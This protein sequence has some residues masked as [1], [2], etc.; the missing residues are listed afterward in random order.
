[1]LTSQTMK[2]TRAMNANQ[3]ILV[4][5]CMSMTQYKIEKKK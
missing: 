4:A 3:R 5:K 1:M 2:R